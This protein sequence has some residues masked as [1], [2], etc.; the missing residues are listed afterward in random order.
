MLFKIGNKD[1]KTISAI[2]FLCFL[3]GS[4]N[5]FCLI[6]SFYDL[7]LKWHC[8]IFSWQFFLLF[9]LKERSHGIVF[10]VLFAHVYYFF[11]IWVYTSIHSSVFDRSVF[12]IFLSGLF[13]TRCH[14]YRVVSNIWLINVYATNC[15]VILFRVY[16]N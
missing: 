7:R 16:I 3:I 13:L 8:Y 15:S 4:L 1:I 2:Q 14:L 9:F 6:Y 11:S 5:N 10:Y 12:C